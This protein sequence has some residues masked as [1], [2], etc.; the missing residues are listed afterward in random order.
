MSRFDTDYDCD[1]FDLEETQKEIRAAYRS[2]GTKA[3][4]RAFLGYLDGMKRRRIIADKF[5]DVQTGEMC[6]VASYCAHKGVSSQHLEEIERESERQRD[7]EGTEESGG[8]DGPTVAAGNKSGLPR[9]VAADL[10]WNNDVAWRQVEYGVKQH[11][12][13]RWPGQTYDVPVYRDMTPEERWLE[14]RNYVARHCGESQIE[15]AA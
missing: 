15:G 7:Y 8:W 5:M 11:T 10:A 1:Q 12:D 9:M 3:E 14:L 4:L 13:Q 6:A 2:K